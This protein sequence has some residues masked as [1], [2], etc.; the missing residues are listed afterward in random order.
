[1]DFKAAQFFAQLF[2]LLLHSLLQWHQFVAD[3]DSA[4]FLHI[5]KSAGNHWNNPHQLRRHAVSCQHVNT[6]HILILRNS[7]FAA[8][9]NSGMIWIPS[10]LSFGLYINCFRKLPGPFD[11][12]KCFTYVVNVVLVGGGIAHVHDKTSVA[13]VKVI[14]TAKQRGRFIQQGGRNGREVFRH[15]IKLRVNFG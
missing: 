8:T 6:A 13:P 10:F 11:F 4:C 2:V 7:S 1:M 9:S 12:F 14:L 15:P 5:T 3:K